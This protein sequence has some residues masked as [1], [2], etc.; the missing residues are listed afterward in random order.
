ML[1]II[2]Q[3]FWKFT[4]CFSCQNRNMW[5]NRFLNESYL[6]ND[7]NVNISPLEMQRCILNQTCSKY[8]QKDIQLLASGPVKIVTCPKVN[9]EPHRRHCIVVLEQDTFIL[10]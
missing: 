7:Q 5:K 10:A 2:D 3:G 9:C 8:L 4:F 6:I 1:I